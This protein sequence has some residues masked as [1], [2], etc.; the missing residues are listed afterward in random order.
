M[1]SVQ[2]KNSD[3]V[4]LLSADFQMRNESQFAVANIMS[5]MEML[6]ELRGL[7]PFSSINENGNAIDM[8][9]QGRTMTNVGAANRGVAGLVPY[10]SLNGTTQYF[11]RAS[12]AGLS[13]ASWLT[14]GGWIAPSN[15]VAGGL[16]S[17]GAGA[18][19][20]FWSYRTATAVI[21]FGIGDG[22]ASFAQVVSTNTAPAAAWNFFACR[23]TPSTELT[24]F[25]NGVKTTN[26][27]GIYASIPANANAL[28]LGRVFGGSPFAGSNSLY[29][30]CAAALSD[31]VINNLY[32]QSRAAFGV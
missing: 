7:W 10:A 13:I 6:P 29:F 15:N 16:L 8:S 3:M 9:G 20:G 14:F 30:L 24:V 27:A 25:L 32:Q 26:A 2:R 31:A 4:G 22:A 1:T 28:E 12:E 5:T 21:V 19:T 18:S 17:K 23:Y 11:S